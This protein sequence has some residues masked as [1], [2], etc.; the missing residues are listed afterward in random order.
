MTNATLR[1]RP[2]TIADAPAMAA[3]YNEGMEDRVATFE[4]TPRTARDLEGWFDGR[5][6]II[7]VID[8]DDQVVGYAATFSYA[9]RC[10]YAGIAEFSVYVRR[11]HRGRGVGA[12]AMT[13]LIDA[14]IK[15][16]FWKLLSRV[17]IENK[18]SLTLL[19]SVGFREV[20]IHEKHGKLDGVWRDVVA[21]ERVLEANL[22]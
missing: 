6:P 4:T 2:A 13:A 15:A 9:D 5:H 8:Q 14:A 7:A 18:A 12:V 3:I 16:G 22:A 17:F 19:R 21:V 20:G 11:S 1:A 10:C